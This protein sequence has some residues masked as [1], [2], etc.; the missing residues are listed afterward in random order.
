MSL[1]ASSFSN[2][3]SKKHFT[4]D[5]LF[6]LGL[7]VFFLTFHLGKGSLTSWDESIYATIA[8]NIVKSG[9]WLRL[10]YQGLPWSDKPPLSIWVTAFFYKIF[11]ISEFSSRFFSSLCGTGTVLVTYLLGRSLFGRWTGLLGALVLLSSSHY[12]HFARFGV[13]DAPLTF[14]LTLSLY[15]FWRGHERDRSLFFSGIAAGAAIMV[16]GAAAFP[17]FPIVWIYCLWA[18]RLDVLTRSSYWVGVIIAVLIAL[19]W[20][21][22]EMALHPNAMMNDSVLR[23]LV[24]RPMSVLDGHDGNFYFYVRTLINKYHPWIL[25]AIWSAPLFLYKAF[26]KRQEEIVFLTVWIFFIF[27]LATLM[28]TKIH[29]YIIPIYPALSLTVGYLLAKMFTEKYQNLVRAAFIAILIAHIPE[30]HI[31]D[32][33]YS[34]D[35]KSLAA[36]VTRTVPEGKA[37]HLYNYHESPAVSF[38]MDRSSIYLEN[39]EEFVRKAKSEPEIYCLIHEKNILTLPETPES[40]GLVREGSVSGPAEDLV[41]LSKKA[42][43]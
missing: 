5:L 3:S 31:F 28:K 39:P 33:N 9:D 32:H 26:R 12:M 27:G 19:P 1:P 40:L 10:Q 42:L 41:F 11:G 36:A 15:F 18:G 37:I 17:I 24:F 34:P 43:T 4:E 20:H 25:I 35:I 21:T 7:S 23:H 38:Y 14:F 29:W 22:Y 13:M 30:S 8:Q 6:L 16:K 2:L